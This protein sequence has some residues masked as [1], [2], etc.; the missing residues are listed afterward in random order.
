MKNTAMR[1]AALAGMLAVL[2]VPEVA[3]ETFYIDAHHGSQEGDGSASNPWQSLQGVLDSGLVETRM[4]SSLPYEEGATLVTKNEG[5]TVRA[6]DTLLLR[7][8]YYGEMKLYDAY[9]E[10]Y[11][12]V[13]AQ[14]GHTPRVRSLHVR[15]AAKWIIRGLSISP[16]HAPTFEATRLAHFESH[17]WR[18]PV[19]EC[20]LE[21]CTLFTVTDASGWSADDWNEL[22][23]SAISL[24][25]AKLT[26]RDNY[27]KN[28]NFG[29]SVSGDSCLV[30]GN[31]IENFSGD[32]LRGLGDY[33]VFRHNAVLN[34]YD[35]NANHD[36]GFQS[37]SRGDDGAVGTGEVVGMVLDGNT[38]INYVDPAQP[39][40]GTLQG[41]GCFDGMFVDWVVRNNLIVTDHWHGITLS[42]AR[43]CRIVNNTVVDLNTDRP[44]PPWVRIGAHKNG[45]ASSGCV[46][47]NNL[48]TS[49]SIDDG[50]GVTADHNIIVSDY[51]DFFVD[52]GSLDFR[53]KPGSPAIDSGSAS[54]APEVDIA[55]TSR[56]QADRVDI[57]AYE[58][59]VPDA[60]VPG[61][62]TAEVPGEARVRV[63][64]TARPAGFTVSLP[65]AWEG[66]PEAPRAR[67]VDSRGCRVGTVRLSGA[68]TRQWRGEL[69]GE[70]AL[71]GGLYLIEIYGGPRTVRTALPVTR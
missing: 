67:L 34:C 25:G 12:T 47:R 23:C 6:G 44:G 10:D 63:R 14:P 46:I 2:A 68:G 16:E 4:W 31:T 11:I 22:A 55:G 37:W 60:A 7:D 61:A 39:F 53:L 65:A 70:A 17:G 64:W 66:V 32:G 26:A 35:V 36:D 24:S 9:N 45:T 21:A 20:V 19:R 18:G 40:R 33:S 27:A 59:V 56:P 52:A 69:P 43:N 38:I 13:A 28:V 54:L 8:G 49:I 5:A 48:T 51:H 62:G 15:A 41:I 29:I 3:A 58:Y 42:G 57:G 1:V 50:Q 30:E 71:A